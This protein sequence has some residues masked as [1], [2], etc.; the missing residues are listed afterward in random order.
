[1]LYSVVLS[2]YFWHFL[3]VLSAPSECNLF[4]FSCLQ[5]YY[6]GTVYTQHIYP[7]F[8]KSRV[9]EWLL[10]VIACQAPI[11]NPFRISEAVIHRQERV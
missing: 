1:M 2:L 3:V 10:F 9:V 6:E 8:S 4:S 11:S 7:F 5:S